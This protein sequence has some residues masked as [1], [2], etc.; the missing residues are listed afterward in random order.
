MDILE[1]PVRALG[2]RRLRQLFNGFWMRTYIVGGAGRGVGCG[3]I[4]GTVEPF[5]TTQTFTG[6][7]ERFKLLGYQVI[8]GNIS[9]EMF[10]SKIKKSSSSGR[11][12]LLTV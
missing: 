6:N 12:K 3:G 11:L 4:G 5:L 2:S 8:E 10:W 7:Q 9:K 1:N